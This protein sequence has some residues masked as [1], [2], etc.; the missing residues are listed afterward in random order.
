MPYRPDSP[1]RLFLAFRRFLFLLIGLGCLG[2]LGE[3]FLLLSPAPELL[4]NRLAKVRRALYGAYTRTLQRL[5]LVR[6]S[7]LTARHDRAR[8]THALARRRRDTGDVG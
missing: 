5:E 3:S 6:R 8:M 7:T 1:Y 2:A 4:R